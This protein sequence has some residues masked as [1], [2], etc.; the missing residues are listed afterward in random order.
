[1]SH[2]WA[3][4]ALLAGTAVLYLWNLSVSGWAN[5]FY[6]AAAQAGSHSWKA[7]L[8]G[9]SDAANSITVDKP[10]L[11]LWPMGGPGG[12]VRPDAIKP[13]G[14]IIAPTG[15]TVVCRYRSASVYRMMPRMLR[16]SSMSL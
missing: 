9:S 5:S 13:A 4:L 16:P 2:P 7:F 3:L 14:G 8:F 15:F 10:P 12:H 6:S 1:L 11:A